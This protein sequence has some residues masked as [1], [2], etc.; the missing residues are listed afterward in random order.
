MTELKAMEWETKPKSVAPTS[1]NEHSNLTSPRFNATNATSMVTTRTN[2]S[3]N[4]DP[5]LNK[6]SYVATST[7]SVKKTT[8]GQKMII[9]RM[10][11]GNYLTWKIWK[12]RRRKST[13]N[14]STLDDR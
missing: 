14:P 3:M 9:T 6:Q 13:K 2:A 5:S 4:H 7:S 11:T 10:T 8:N 1:A 12:E